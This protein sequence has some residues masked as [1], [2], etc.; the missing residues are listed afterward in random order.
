MLSLLKSLGAGLRLCGSALVAVGLWTLWLALTIL[1][2]FQLRIATTNELAVPDFILRRLERR[3]AESGVRTTFSRARFDPTGRILIENARVLLPAFAEPVLTARTIYVR[4]NPWLLTVGRFEASEIRVT[5]GVASVPA[6]LSPSGRAEEVVRELDTTLVL[7]DRDITLRQFSARIAGIAVSARGGIQ[8]RA[9]GEPA[10]G[11]IA[12]FIAR[13]FPALCRQIAAAT[14]QIAGFEA[15]SLQLELTP[16]ETGAANISVALLARGATLTTPVAAQA[17]NVRVATQ[18][19]LF[20]EA[21]PTRL[22][23]SAQELQLPFATTAHG[24]QATVVGQLRPGSGYAFAPAEIDVTIESLA[25][26]GYSARAVSAQVKSDPLP[27]F[28]ADLVGQ[29]M[30]AP[31]AVTATGDLAAR[32]AVL[33]FAGAISPTVLDPLSQRLG[34]N[35]RRY[36]DF[37]SLACENGEVRLGPGW[38]FEKLTARLDLPHVS[39]YGVKLSDGQATVEFDGRRF[40]SPEAY[41]RVGDN[42]ARGSYEHDLKTHGFRFLLDGQ[43]RPLDIGPWFREWW[44]D[45]FQQLAFPSTP[46]QASVDVAGFWREGH[47]TSVF[48]FAEVAQSV[49]RGAP[50][51]RVRTR[52][53][54]RPGFFDGLEVSARQGSGAAHGTFNFS[55]D[56]GGHGWRSFDLNLD[57]TLDVGVAAKIVGPA[58]ASILAPYAFTAPPT[59]TLA[60]R[61]EGPG[62][63]HGPHATLQLT[64][65]T[66]GEFRFHDFPLRDTS[67]QLAI[68][69]DEI[70]VDKIAATAAGGAVSGQVRV[71]GQGDQRRVAFEITAKDASLGES[72]G[73]VQEFLARR[74]HD[75]PAPPGKFIKEKANVRLDLTAAAE[76]SY[77]DPFSYRGSGNAMIRGP[78]IGEVPLLGTLSELLPFTALR[79]TEARGS[80]K[81][82]GPKVVFSEVIVHGSNSLIEAR[83]DYALDARKLDFRAKVF[84]FQESGNLIKSVVGVVLTPFSNALEVKLTGALEKPEWELVI[85]SGNL[86]DPR[87]ADAPESGAKTNAVDGPVAPSGANQPAT[88]PLPET[89]PPTGQK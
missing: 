69:D 34:V 5:D 26:E 57:S 83:G 66:A 22:E 18:V 46:P 59:V 61:F 6:M 67:F 24:V 29:V 40:H 45:F 32:S 8:V 16:L 25:A 41:A 58:G 63:P 51:D 20:G 42:F 70:V 72:V 86:L 82:A 35:V 74:R 64:A 73:T 12:D 76:G 15:P 1:L 17:R 47:R 71:W 84:P 65:R 3:L 4:L 30:G 23:F 78:E 55:L 85:S 87:P 48:V 89:R 38:K 44:P 80:Y 50:L 52:L 75:P 43:L 7:G 77:A 81:I 39:A 9:A 36:F 14:E 13:R 27:R 10:A 62:S 28:H 31:L 2:F 79:F 88:K 56:P 54:I 21:S 68:K 11:A 37:T 49:F 60:G 33:G 19:Q 53:F